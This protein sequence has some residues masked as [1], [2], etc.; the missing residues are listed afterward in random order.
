MH[1]SVSRRIMLL[2]SPGETVLHGWVFIRLCSPTDSGTRPTS[3]QPVG[4][5]FCA[6]VAVPGTC[7]WN[8]CNISASVSLVTEI[9]LGATARY[10]NVILYDTAI[11]SSRDLSFWCNVWS[12]VLCGCKCYTHFPEI[13]QHG[14]EYWT[15]GCEMFV[16]MRTLGKQSWNYSLLVPMFDKRCWKSSIKTWTLHKGSLSSYVWIWVLDKQSRN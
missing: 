10:R 1:I 4:P 12:G 9:T 8:R 15:R 11:S 13:L 16:L 6:M 14:F 7:T 3:R 2:E 5:Q